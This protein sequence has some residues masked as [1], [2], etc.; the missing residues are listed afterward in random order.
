VHLKIVLLHHIVGHIKVFKEANSWPKRFA[1]L[2][3][4][5][6]ILLLLQT[7]D[8]SIIKQP[9]D[10]S[11]GHKLGTLLAH[12]KSH[13]HNILI[14]LVHNIKFQFEV[15]VITLVSGLLCI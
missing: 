1:V 3:L 12:L 13:T 10:S 14:L 11:F 8:N 2:S 4:L 7:Q 15:Q 5:H 6:L 9:L